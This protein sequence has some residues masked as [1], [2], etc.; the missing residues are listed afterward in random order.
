MQLDSDQVH[1]E[2]VQ[3]L[4]HEKTTTHDFFQAWKRG[5]ELAGVELFGRG[6]REVFDLAQT[7]W[8]L[9]PNLLLIT[10]AIGPMSSGERVFLA[11]LVSFYDAREGGVL[12]RRVGVEGLAD[13][14]RLDRQRREVLAELILH[15][16]G[17]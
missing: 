7:K 9:C 1:R 10:D 6:T 13:L 12:L 3:H 14:G 2:L 11:A 5:V 17:W 15:Y 8:E 4:S 16:S